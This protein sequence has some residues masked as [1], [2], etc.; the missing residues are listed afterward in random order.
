MSAAGTTN[1]ASAAP[2][3]SEQCAQFSLAMNL[4]SRRW[5][6]QILR[7]LLAGPRRYNELLDAI[8]GL[9]DPLLTQ[10]LRE[11]VDN[12]L[13]TRNVSDCSPVRVEYGLTEAGYDLEEAIRAIAAW[14]VKW[15]GSLPAK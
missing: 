6:G 1:Q 4:L 14:A 5:M 2:L 3:V 11:L 7:I 12:K 8:E 13:A 10:R 15:S 9:S